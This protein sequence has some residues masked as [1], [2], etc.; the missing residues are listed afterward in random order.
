MFMVTPLSFLKRA[1]ESHA[2]SGPPFFT[3]RSGDFSSTTHGSPH[4]FK[5]SIYGSGSNSSTL[6]TPF[7]VPFFLSPSSWRRS[8]PVRRW[9]R[10]QPGSPPLYSIPD[11]RRH[12]RYKWSF[13]FPS[14]TPVKIQ[15]MLVFPTVLGPK[16]AGSGKRAFKNWIGT[17][18]WPLYSTGEVDNIPTFSRHFHMGSDSSGR[19]HEETDP[20][21]TWDVLC[22]GLDLLV[23]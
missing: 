13:S 19:G 4:L 6:N 7:A 21:Y 3:L 22:Q 5:A 23:M 12:C 14:F 20:L 18:S 17:I 8:W 9:C 16:D 11:G 2:F 10:K 1:A 15:P